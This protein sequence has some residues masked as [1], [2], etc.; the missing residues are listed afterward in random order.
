M[1]QGP[2]KRR[3]LRYAAWFAVIGLATACTVAVI[4]AVRF[5]PEDLA[6]LI[7]SR[8]KERT[9]RELVI[10]GPVSYSVSF[11]PT[12]KA[13]RVR[14][15]NA[16][17][18]TR[19][20][21]LVAR[22]VAIQIALLPLLG[23]RVQV[24]GIELS[25]PDVLFEVARDRRSNWHFESPE[26]DAAGA[27]TDRDTGRTSIRFLGIEQGAFAYRDA[28]SGRELRL[29]VRELEVE[30]DGRRA[31]IR[32]TGAYNDV[33]VDIAARLPMPGARSAARSELTLT[34]PGLRVHAAG[35]AA[36]QPGDLTADVAFSAVVQ[37]WAA[38]AKLLQQ[39][40]A[41]MPPLEAS[42]TLRSDATGWALENIEARL[43]ESRVT[44]HARWMGTAE[45]RR[46]DVRLDSPLVDLA[47][48]LGAGKA[49][50]PSGGRLF[51]AEPFPLALL[52]GLTGNVEARIARLALR[53]GKAVQGVQVAARFDRGS[54][55]LDPA[56]LDVDGK[57]L[58]A[59]V[60]ADAR[61]GKTLR[62][63][64]DVDARGV[65]LGA[66]GALLDVTGTPEGSPTD[67]S[68][69]MAATGRSVR[70][71]M[72]SASGDVQV[73]VGP[74]RIRNRVVKFGADVTELL[75]LLN[76]AYA[77]DPY[78]EVKCVVV[79]LPVRQGVVRIDNSIG[80]ETS[81]VNVLAAG[82]IDL[83]DETL[84]LGFRTRPATGL[85]VSLGPLAELGR[86]RG[87]LADPEVEVDLGNAAE[88]AAH[89]GLAAITGG[90]SLIASGLLAER[91]PD[92]PCEVALRGG[93][94]SRKASGTR[95]EPGVVDSVIGNI[96]KLFGH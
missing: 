23:G 8:V 72:A 95:E 78:T 28:E 33:P 51:S 82:T 44:G 9:G 70:A 36:W 63:D 27:K 96:K 49:A 56:Q 25:D 57:P 77:A 83:R 17:W 93:G 60:H 76:P 47:P 59:R 54:M 91:V 75:K 41:A 18:G 21:M 40:F 53:D 37:D 24:R 16:S 79:R 94:R 38:A 30:N 14:L 61:G 5:A 88:A 55:T 52:A 65:P 66:L 64:L 90:L 3:W 1:S 81:K 7:T 6:R 62:L 89:I 80:A 92:H 45:D 31:E 12:L 85:G 71:L 39:D 35:S 19:P 48:L 46:F 74:G 58:R 32:G 34:G 2:A 68:L 11:F 69:R 10:D 20:D 4:V 22:E 42:G 29:T 50:P 73:V 43:G 13:Q 84:D 67:V 15:Q 86:L 26:A 87:T